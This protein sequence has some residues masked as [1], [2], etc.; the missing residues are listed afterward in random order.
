[1]V[2]EKYRKSMSNEVLHSW[3]HD[4][5]K[6][7]ELLSELLEESIANREE[8]LNL[9]QEGRDYLVKIRKALAK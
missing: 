7:I 3:A 8:T 4:A 5:Q 9:S 6:K 2:L 1:M